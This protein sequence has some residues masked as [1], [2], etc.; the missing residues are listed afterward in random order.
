MLMGAGFKKRG[1]YLDAAG[2]LNCNSARDL[3]LS[4]K[5]L[6]T[7]LLLMIYISRYISC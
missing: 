3:A 6:L 2:Q 4:R 5:V 7:N 1:S